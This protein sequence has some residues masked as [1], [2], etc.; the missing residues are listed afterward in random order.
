ML[1]FLRY[2]QPT[3]VSL[4]FRSPRPLLQGASDGQQQDEA[5]SRE[6]VATARHTCVRTGDTESAD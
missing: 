4:S 1:K 3:L 5:G 2:S 6:A